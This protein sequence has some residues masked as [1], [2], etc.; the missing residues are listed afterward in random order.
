MIAV[1]RPGCAWLGCGVSDDTFFDKFGIRLEA[2][3][4]LYAAAA[5]AW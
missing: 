3:T 1:N 4:A 5:A 2:A